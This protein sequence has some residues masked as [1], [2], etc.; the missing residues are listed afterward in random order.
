[1]NR[2]KPGGPSDEWATPQDL[3][4]AACKYYDIEP[5]LDLAATAENTK[6]VDFN[7]KDAAFKQLPCGFDVW[8]NPPYSN[9]LPFVKEGLICKRG[10][11]L[12]KCDPS[13]KVFKFC[14]EWA[15]EIALMNWRVKFVGAPN[16]ATFPTMLVYFNSSVPKRGARIVSLNKEELFK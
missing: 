8:C 6:C 5:D 3:F 7:S 1:M 4:E 12:L 9:S 15:V 16:V 2:N 11:F 10:V 14:A 13:T